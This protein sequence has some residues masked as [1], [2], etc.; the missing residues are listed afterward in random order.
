LKDKVTIAGTF[1]LGI[2]QEH[3]SVCIEDQVYSVTPDTTKEFF[4]KEVLAK[5]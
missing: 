4:E 3:V 1:C 2:C 5:L